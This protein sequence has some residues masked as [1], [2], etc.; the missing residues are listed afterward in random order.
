MEA[1]PTRGMVPAARSQGEPGHKA[2]SM[3]QQLGLHLEEAEVRNTSVLKRQ[4]MDPLR[5]EKDSK[6][7]D[8]GALGR[9]PSWH[10]GVD[11]PMRRQS[12]IASK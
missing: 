3:E 7:E 1:T 12:R 5:Q 6:G 8:A 2:D 4:P 10:W 9:V 11:F